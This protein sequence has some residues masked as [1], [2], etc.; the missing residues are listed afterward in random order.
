MITQRSFDFLMMVVFVL[1]GVL[2]VFLG[3][4]TLSVFSII[5]FLIGAYMI[6]CA[7]KAFMNYENS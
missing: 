1:L 3:F 6:H 2:N 5:N 7:H 4:L